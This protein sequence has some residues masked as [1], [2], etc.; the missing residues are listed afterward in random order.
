MQV[1]QKKEAELHQ[2][3]EMHKNVHAAWTEARDRLTE[4]QERRA[5]LLNNLKEAQLQQE[6]KAHELIALKADFAGVCCPFCCDGTCNKHCACKVAKYASV[7]IR[8]CQVM[9]ALHG[10][11]MQAHSPASR[12]L[13]AGSRAAP[14]GTQRVASRAHEEEAGD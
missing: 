7:I 9:H 12:P 13:A 4:H 2:R 14:Q 3:Q 5:A 11:P 8:D 6:A 10:R 1:L